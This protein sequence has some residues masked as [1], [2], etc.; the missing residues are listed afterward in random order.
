M[1]YQRTHSCTDFFCVPPDKKLLASAIMQIFVKHVMVFLRENSVNNVVN[2]N[3][4]YLFLFL[5][6]VYAKCFQCPPVCL[7]IT[8]IILVVAESDYFKNSHQN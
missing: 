6:F 8:I 3:K 1:F 7:F 5:S 2:C 4:Q